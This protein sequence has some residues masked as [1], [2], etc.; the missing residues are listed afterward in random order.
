MAWI[1]NIT[2]FAYVP[3][4]STATQLQSWVVSKTIKRSTRAPTRTRKL[5][6]LKRIRTIVKRSIDIVYKYIYAG[7]LSTWYQQWCGLAGLSSSSYQQNPSHTLACAAAGQFPPPHSSFIPSS[8]KGI[9]D[10]PLLFK[11]PRKCDTRLRKYAKR[12]TAA[13]PA[14]DSNACMISNPPTPPSFNANM[15]NHGI[16]T[17]HL[18][19]IR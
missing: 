6:K 5:Q 15:Q 13:P 17:G 8:Q 7:R 9:W 1:D 3:I 14:S 12:I 19:K 2:L 10:F 18:S 16:Q 4:S 11:K